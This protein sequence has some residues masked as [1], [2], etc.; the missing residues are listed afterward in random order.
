MPISYSVGGEWLHHL[1]VAYKREADPSVPDAAA[2]LAYVLDSFLSL[3]E[4]CAAQA[5]GLERFTL[6]TTVP[7]SDWFRDQWHPLRSV[8]GRLTPATADRY[9]RLLVSTPPEDHPLRARPASDQ[10]P[11]SRRFDPGRYTA[12]CRL[13]GESVLLIDDMWTT[14]ASAQSAAAALRAAGAGQVVAVVIGRHLNR[15]WDQNNARLRQLAAGGFS[16]A[17]CVRCR[18]G[19][20]LSVGDR[21]RQ[22]RGSHPSCT[23]AV[24]VQ[25]HA[26][27]DHPQRF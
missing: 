1:I 7:S 13:N 25:T 9:A 2:Q 11:A 15:G 16:F 10:R 20:G 26:R 22:V 5:V 17:R 3:H 19:L 14:G 18:D 24:T 4:R 21:L 23:H 12:T 6:V 8:V 27:S